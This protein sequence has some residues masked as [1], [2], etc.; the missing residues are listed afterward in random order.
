MQDNTIEVVLTMIVAIL[1]EVRACISNYIQG[2]LWDVVTL[3][4][5][6]FNGDLINPPLMLGMGG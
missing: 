6:N 1:P 5:P 3:P 4:H 2:S